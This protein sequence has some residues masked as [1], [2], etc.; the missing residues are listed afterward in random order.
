MAEAFQSTSLCSSP[1]P[2]VLGSLRFLT[3]WRPV[4][5]GG[6][7]HVLL[8]TLNVNVQPV[9][10]IVRAGCRSGY[11]QWAKPGIV[12]AHAWKGLIDPLGTFTPEYALWLCLDPKISLSTGTGNS[13]SPSSGS[14]FCEGDK[15]FTSL[16]TRDSL[17]IRMEITK[18]H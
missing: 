11:Q 5:A 2:P 3:A 13:H 9:C 6:V 14:Y 18:E 10:R 4:T 1:A 17:G 12:P 7:P 8:P 16:R 15:T